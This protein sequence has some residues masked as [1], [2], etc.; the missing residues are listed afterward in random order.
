MGIGSLE[1]VLQFTISTYHKFWD[2]CANQIIPNSLGDLEANVFLCKIEKYYV[3]FY[4]S[5]IFGS[6]PTFRFFSMDLKRKWP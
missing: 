6:I 1:D 5:S 2:E 4:E 3:S